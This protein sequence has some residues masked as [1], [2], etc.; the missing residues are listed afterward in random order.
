MEGLRQ[1]S[2]APIIESNGSAFEM[3]EVYDGLE[4]FKVDPVVMVDELIEHQV[5]HAIMLNNYSSELISKG[6]DSNSSKIIEYSLGITECEKE[7][8]WLQE[9]DLSDPYELFLITI[10]YQ[11]LMNQKPA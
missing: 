10:K 9:A 2:P 7:I 11:K 1:I 6:L 3:P 8:D 5:H 4:C